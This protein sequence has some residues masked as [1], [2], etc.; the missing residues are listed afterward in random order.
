MTALLEARALTRTFGHFTAVDGVSFHVAPGEVVGL[1]GANGAGKTTAIRMLLGLLRP[2]SGEALLDGSPPNRESRRR[3]GYVPQSLGLY[4]ELTALENLAFAAQAFGCPPATLEGPLADQ[5]D[6]LVAAL[7]LGL[8]RQLAFLCA[9]QHTPAVLVLDEP[10]SGVGPLA[11]THLWDRIREEAVR[12]AGVLVTTHYMQEARQCDRLLL[13]SDGRLV[14]TGREADIV[15]GTRT[16]S[17]TAPDWSRTFQLLAG[18]G[19]M[20]TL[21]GRAVRVVDPDDARLRATLAEAG[22][23]AT[24]TDVVP[25]IEERMTALA[26]A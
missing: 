25:S 2:S 17:V 1:L 8:R 21:A 16:V 11:R 10:T 3:L 12:G 26:H 23:D 14:A 24:L 5:G 19:F 9:L 4:S 20:V 22:L 6:T 7:P 18:A 15:D 13:M